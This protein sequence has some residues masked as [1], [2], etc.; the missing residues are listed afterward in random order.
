MTH[1][2]E[3]TL[4][5]YIEGILSGQEEFEV[6]EHI[7]GC[8]GCADRFAGMMSE[9]KLVSPPP[10]LKKEILGRTVYRKNPVQAIQRMQERKREKRREFLAYSAR[11]VFATAAS[12]LIVFTM[13]V[14]TSSKQREM[15]VEIVQMRQQEKPRAEKKNLISDSLHKA[16]GKMGDALQGFLTMFNRQEEE[17][18]E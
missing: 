11:V 4:Q 8:D 7:A 3:E 1:I 12:V 2:N 10:D 13:S 6:M 5:A 14:S 18:R 9:E 16:S 17:E 15:P